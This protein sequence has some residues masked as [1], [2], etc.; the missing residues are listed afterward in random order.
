MESKKGGKERRSYRIILPQ[1]EK[2][3][4]NLGMEN[5]V[6]VNFHDLLKKR[7]FFAFL[8]VRSSLKFNAKPF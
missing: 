8:N 3:L 5:I 4:G 2:I 1:A 7:T 6:V